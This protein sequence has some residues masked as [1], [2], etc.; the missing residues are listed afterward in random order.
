MRSGKLLAPGKPNDQTKGFYRF[1]VPVKAGARAALEVT[2]ESES[3]EFWRL[4]D[5]NHESLLFFART[6]RRRSPPF[7]RASRS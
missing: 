1:D 2:E 7:A 5:Q 6:S 3:T 4:V